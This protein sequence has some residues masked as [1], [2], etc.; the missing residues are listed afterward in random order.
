M[1]EPNILTWDILRDWLLNH[2]RPY[3]FFDLDGTLIDL[4]PRPDAVSVSPDLIANLD[5]LHARFAGRVAIVSGRSL[6][7][8]ESLVPVPV[9]LVGNHGAEFR[10]GSARWNV[11]QNRRVQDAFD[12]LRPRLR[13]LEAQFPG[14]FLE[15]K[16]ATISFHV[17]HLRPS[18]AEQAPMA[19]QRLVDDEAGL[20]LRPAQTCWEIRPHKGLDKGLAL[21]A[22]LGPGGKVQPI[23]FGDDVTDEDA[24]QAATRH[25]GLTVVVGPRRPTQAQFSLNQPSD[26]RDLLPR[27]TS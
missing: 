6:A 20:V 9:T 15:D 24:F 7:D 26:L 13:A 10:Q 1:S 12:R 8:L 11:T 25:Q 21:E 14:A 3:W 19:L 2:P 5:R 18:D 27:L 16:G 22:L 17:R 4:A 23:V